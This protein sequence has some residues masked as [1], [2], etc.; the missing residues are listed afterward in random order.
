MMET[1]DGY[2]VCETIR[3]DRSALGAHLMLTAKSRGVEREKRSRSAPT[4][5]S[6]NRSQPAIWSRVKTI[7]V[8]TAGRRGPQAEHRS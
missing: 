1:L 8:P 2:H 3:A 6:R 5:T 7:L 4:T